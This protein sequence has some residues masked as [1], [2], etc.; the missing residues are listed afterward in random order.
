MTQSSNCQIGADA[1]R[2]VL[3][4]IDEFESSFEAHADGRCP[5]GTCSD[6]L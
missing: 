5:S 3:T 6:K 1:P 4:A 2:P